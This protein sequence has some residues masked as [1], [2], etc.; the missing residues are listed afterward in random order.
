MVVKWEWDMNLGK[1]VFVAAC[2]VAG[3]ASAT[4]AGVTY[5]LTP[6]AELAE[7]RKENAKLDVA[8]ILRDV[9]VAAQAP[10]ASSE[11]AASIEIVFGPED[12][13]RLQ[14]QVGDIKHRQDLL[15]RELVLT[16][17]SEPATTFIVWGNFIFAG[18]A[19][20]VG[21]LGLVYGR[22]KD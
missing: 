17:K 7:V 6:H 21:V 11:S 16:R 22:S 15:E 5:V 4:L 9:T 13:R 12:F 19:S 8:R 3:L 18:V 20:V 2:F 1:G 10:P 14:T